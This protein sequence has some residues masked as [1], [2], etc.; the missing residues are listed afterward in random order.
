MNSAVKKFQHR[1]L[2]VGALCVVSTITLLSF[3]PS[4]INARAGLNLDEEYI[5]APPQY[6]LERQP[7]TV[8]TLVAIRPSYPV[9]IE[10]PNIYVGESYTIRTA[11]TG[12]AAIEYTR[13]GNIVS[14]T[15]LLPAQSQIIA[16][17]TKRRIS[18]GSYICPTTGKFTSGFGKRSSSGIESTNHKGIDIANSTGTSVY[19]ADGGTIYFAGS[20]SPYGGY[21]NL[22]IIEH[23]NGDLTYYGH[24][25]KIL[26]K[27]GAIVYQGDEIGKM[28]S[29]GNSTAPHLHFEYRP[30]GGE[31]V[32][33]LTII[34]LE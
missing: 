15:E 16:E 13:D 12:V 34:T 29:T 23:E 11:E 22:I 27:E 21:G 31:P 19:A 8:G 17:G 6:V 33:P 24:L 32:D 10:D 5:P 9:Y 26:V 2:T 25:S 14:E 30:G 3:A 28:G 20:G 7:E 18:T 4:A 1:I